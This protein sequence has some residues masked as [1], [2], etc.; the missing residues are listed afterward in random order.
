MPSPTLLLTHSEGSQLLCW[1][2]PSGG[3][4][5][6]EPMSPANSREDLRSTP[7][8]LPQSELRVTTGL[9]ITFTVAFCDTEQEGVP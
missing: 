8:L 9:A 1:E 7:R 3:P 6:K 5:D 2:Q 4:G